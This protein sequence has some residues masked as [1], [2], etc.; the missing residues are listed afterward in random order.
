MQRSHVDALLTSYRLHLYAE[1][2][3]KMTI[4]GYMYGIGAYVK[5]ADERGLVDLFDR[6]SVIAWMASMLDRGVEPGSVVTWARGPRLFSAWC[7]EEGERDHDPLLRLPVPRVPVKVPT[8]LT[9]GQVKLLLSSCG[10]RA[11]G[12]V[13]DRAAIMTLYD[14]GM[15]IGELLALRVDQVDLRAGQILIARSKNGKGRIVPVGAQAC[16]A[17]DRYLRARSR[18]VRRDSQTLFLSVRGAP[19]TYHAAETQL[20]RRA[21]SVGLPQFHVHCL[22]ASFAINWT[23]SGGDPASMLQICGWQDLRMAQRYMSSASA[24]LAAAEHRRFS[25]G[26]AL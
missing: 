13:R 16:R 8:A 23:E 11:Y 24:R 7:L 18:Y 3:S 20:K 9:P 4:T 21:V 22:R 19:W 5:Y 6:D 14:S 12:D 26:D 1:A 17:L 2:K 25:P 15:R 10:T